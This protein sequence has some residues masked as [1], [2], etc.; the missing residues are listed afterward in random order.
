MRGFFIFWGVR[1]DSNPQLPDPQS[2]ALPLSYGHHFCAAG[3]N[4][5]PDAMLFQKFKKVDYIITRQNFVLQNFRR[6]QALPIALNA[7]VLPKGIVSTP[8]RQN[9][10][11]LGSGLS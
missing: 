1:R 7:I 8:S 4:R 3:V 11:G 9:F 5:T 2:G 6:G 10:G